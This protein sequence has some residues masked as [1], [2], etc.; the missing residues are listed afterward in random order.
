[1][2]SMI[3][4]LGIALLLT[5]CQKTIQEPKSI[6]GTWESI[7]AGWLLQIQDSTQY[8]LYDTTDI[9]CLL[10]RKAGLEE[11]MASLSLTNDT[12]HLKKGV[13]TYLFTR[14][15][16]T[17]SLCT[18]DRTE[19]QQQD[20]L[21][22]FEVFAQT[23]KEH[24]V[25]MELNN[26][27]WQIL[28]EEQKRKLT[29][30]P[31]DTNLYNVL[32]ETLE[33]LG[34]NHAFL[35]ASDALYTALEA[36]PQKE[37]EES[38]T[39]DEEQE[40]GDFQIANMVAEEYLTKDM[41]ADSW[42]VKWGKMENN[43]GYIQLKA[44]WLYAQLDIPQALVD[45][46]GFVDAYV[47]TFHT[48]DEGQ[49]VQ[50]EVKGIIKLMDRVMNDL[51]DTKAMVID[52]RFN[53]GG[54]DA[55]SFEILKRFNDQKRKTVTT[56]LK[57]KDHFSPEL[58]LYLDSALTPYTHPVYILTSPQTGSAAE[59]FAISSMA[60][61]HHKRIGAST[62]GA[63]STA[64]EKTLPNGW[65]FSISNEVYMDLKGNSYENIGVP[66]DYTISYPTDRQAF[67]RSVANDLP[68]DKQ[69]ILDAIT[70]L[71]KQ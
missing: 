8:A 13:M 12:L 20:P 51:K 1:M 5:S 64:L 55:V 65:A 49:Y 42:L 59:A 22:N 63:L 36:I 9:S 24:Y 45:E 61:P 23:V 6:N 43:I 46:I 69:Q 70:H 30:N 3:I 7:G 40:Y 71:E 14:T 54:Q 17:P 35:E 16:E 21:H 4:A 31:T 27:D 66:V 19:E 2:K 67:F 10:N 57:H 60:I 25:F 26:I 44:M 48:M 39:E 47:T 38:I 15:E 11:I 37:E 29:Q 33:K 32:E 52:V 62:Q 68:K 28:Y 18:T 56:K 58:P 53:G 41:T 50:K 34:D